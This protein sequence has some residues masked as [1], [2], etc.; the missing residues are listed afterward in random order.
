MSSSRFFQSFWWLGASCSLWQNHCQPPHS[1]ADPCDAAAK[2]P[3]QHNSFTLQSENDCYQTG[4]TL[5]P[6]CTEYPIGITPTPCIPPT[7]WIRIIAGTALHLSMRSVIR[8]RR[9]FERSNCLQS[10]EYQPGL[11]VCPQSQQSP[12]R[13]RPPTAG[14]NT[15]STPGDTLFRRPFLGTPT[16][17][18]RATAD[19]S[20]IFYTGR[21]LGATCYSVRPYGA[22]LLPDFPHPQI[23]RFPLHHIHKF[24]L[25]PTEAYV[26]PHH[27]YQYKPTPSPSH[28][29]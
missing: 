21:G 22:P 10:A 27:T 7:G 5:E 3:T 18:Q 25:P 24:T 14:E 6:I 26:T 23:R 11:L 28:S 1:T 15:H 17:L 20:T 29:T 9:K 16:S 8:H 13:V 19:S 2:F 12:H 4:P